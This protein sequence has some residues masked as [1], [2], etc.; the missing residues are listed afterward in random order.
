[1]IAESSWQWVTHS[2]I[3]VPYFLVPSGISPVVSR[4]VM[5]HACFSAVTK[6]SPVTLGLGF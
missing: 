6:T 4:V 3:F 5:V 1:M 2:G